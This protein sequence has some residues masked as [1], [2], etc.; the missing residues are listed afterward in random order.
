MIPAFAS[1]RCAFALPLLLAASLPATASAQDLVKAKDGSG[2]FGYTNTPVLPWCGYHVHDPDRPAPPRIDPGP[3]PAPAPVP[4]DAVVL[5]DAASPHLDAF[6]PADWKVVDHGELQAGDK[7]LESTRSFGSCQIHVEWKGP[8][9]NDGSWANQGNN[10]VLLM[11]LYEIQ[12]YD[13]YN[14][15]IYPDGM[16]GAIYGQTPPLANAQ[17]AP[18]QWQSMDILLKA[19]VYEGTK[20]VQPPRV[21]ILHNGVL[22]QLDEPIRGTTNHAVLPGTPPPG[23]VAGPLVLFGHHSPVKFRSVWVRPLLA[24]KPKRG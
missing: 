7:L 16:T 18:E 17:R 6:K 20:Q 12:I 15:K 21:T 9:F 4:S 24:P 23:V 5:F 22:V 3:A 14:V 19:P 8:P 1:R 10:G 2:V 11:G 13:N